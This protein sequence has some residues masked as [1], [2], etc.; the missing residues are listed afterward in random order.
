M[1]AVTHKPQEPSVRVTVATLSGTVMHMSLSYE[2]YAAL[3][4]WVSDNNPANDWFSV[5][6]QTGEVAIFRHSCI[7]GMTAD[8]KAARYQLATMTYAQQRGCVGSA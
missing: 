3:T 2:D 8:L 7:E 1:T 6:T 5:D 4:S